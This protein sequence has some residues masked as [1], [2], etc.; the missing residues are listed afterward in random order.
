MNLPNTQNIISTPLAQIFKS[1]SATYKFYWFYSIL[2][3]IEA[4]KTETTQT[5]LIASMIG[6]VWFPITKYRLSFGK[7]DKLANIV[8]EILESD[9]LL[10]AFE[11][12]TKQSDIVTGILAFLKAHPKSKLARNILKLGNYVPYRFLSPWCKDILKNV[13]DSQVEQ[14]IK[15]YASDIDQNKNLPYF[16]EN[17]KVIFQQ[18]WLTYFKENLRICYDYCFW[19]LLEFLQKR[20]PNVPNIA[21]KLFPP[22]PK[23]R[24]LSE[25]RKYWKI[26][27]NELETPL[28][29]IFSGELIQMEDYALDHFIPWSFVTHNLLWNLVP[30][31]PSV[32]SSKSDNLPDLNLY[33]KKFGNLQFEAFHIWQEKGKKKKLEDYL[34]IGHSINEIS[35][36]SKSDFILKLENQIKP[37]TQIAQNMGFQSNWTY[38][39]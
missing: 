17:D 14:T 35:Q 9:N 18:K 27:S 33:F 30:I 26:I 7:Q 8:D 15:S 5:E 11:L 2:Q 13:K 4:N 38:Q 34:V 19:N 10:L 28:R 24:T 20:N 32:N 39:K 21:G 1:T 25:E 12:K 3:I 37:L 36:L 16:F 29:C 22:N 31:V 6:N 23:N